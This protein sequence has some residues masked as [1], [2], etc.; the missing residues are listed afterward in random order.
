MSA[1]HTKSLTGITSITTPPG[2]DNVFTVHSNDTTERFR[3][4]LNGNQSIAGILTVAQDL[5]VDGHTNLDNVSISG[6]T[7]ASDNIIIP[8]DKKLILGTQSGRQL[9]LYHN[10][11]GSSNHVIESTS[12]SN[13]FILKASVINP[14]ANYFSFRNLAH[15]QNVFI[16][17]ADNSTKLYFNG[18]E[19]LTTENTGVNIT[20]IVT[21]TSADING[22]LDVDGHTNLDNVSIAGVT[23]FTGVVKIPTVVG[24]NTNADLNVLF[25]TT[26]GVIDGGSAL[27]YNPAQDVLSVNGNHISRQTFRGHG[28]LGTLTCDNHSSTTF[29]K[30]SNT[31]DIGTVDNASGAFTVKQ[32]SNEYIT[33]DTNNSSELIKFGTA[34]SER[35][36]INSAGAVMVGGTLQAGSNG[37]LNAEVTDSGN[38]RVP[39][40]L[41]NQGTADGSGVIISHRGKDDAGNQE[42]YNYIRMVADDTGNGSEDG[43]IRF[44]T[45]AGGT[46]AQRVRIDSN[47]LNLTPITNAARNAGVSTATGTIIYNSTTS[48][49]Q[50]YQGT[51]WDTLSNV[52]FAPTGGNATYTFGNYTVHA[53]TSNGNFVV[54][55]SGTVDVLVVAG[56]G[57][58]GASSRN[59]YNGAWAGGG[60]AGGVLY[61]TGVSVT[62][63]TYSIVIGAGGA[64]G[65]NGSNS[66][67]LGYTAIGG[68]RGG[69]TT[70]SSNWTGGS[71]GSGGGGLG[72]QP[73]PYQGGSG[74]SGQGNAGGPGTDPGGNPYYEQG[75]GGGGAGEA[76]NTDGIA[77]GGD[78]RDMSG[79]FGTTYGE[80][81]YFGGGGAGGQGTDNSNTTNEGGVGGGG[82]SGRGYQN[83][84]LAPEAGAANTGGGGGAGGTGSG[85]GGA[86]GGSGI[87]LIRYLT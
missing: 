26:A 45:V 63:Q 28:S 4:D 37:G 66:S 71:G 47:G 27:T 21:A 54:N 82:N 35:L 70:S 30:V 15:N 8:D 74:T 55:T 80:N 65:S 67:A 53:F 5:D 17:D 62:A 86:A 61:T 34:G 19:K 56:G 44:W 75:G 20:G 13:H 50:V 6:V 38:Q 11:V 36:R 48:T 85:T 46:L 60:G 39:L 79:Q 42:D 40:A 72:D 31:V 33:V 76:G 41:I 2:V 77:F 10:L 1:I 69:G 3:V 22:D 51:K 18:N 29:V 58:G 84:S 9:H 7:T 25:Q 14:R 59:Q 83:S 81:G 64:V 78:G 68:G 43:S 49:M 57:G 24:T 23:T 52:A 16:V 12:S 73:G 32:G 87:V